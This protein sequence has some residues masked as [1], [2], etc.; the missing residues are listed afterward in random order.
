MTD[1]SVREFARPFPIA[2]G[3]SNKTP[4][5][6]GKQAG[7]LHP[8]MPAPPFSGPLKVPPLPAAIA[9]RGGMPRS[10]T[11]SAVDAAALAALH[12]VFAAESVALERR[13]GLSDA[14]GAS[15]QPAQPSGGLARVMQRL[16]RGQ[17]V[18]LHVVGGS[19]AAGA[20]GV[21]E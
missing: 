12:R 15:L 21:G 3:Q 5:T 2:P 9:A 17:Q 7:M 19:A 10:S 20:G 4:Q 14:P 6:R 1:L 11:A 13:H 8:W 18:V 16:V